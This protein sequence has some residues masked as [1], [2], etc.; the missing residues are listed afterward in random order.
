LETQNHEWQNIQQKGR[1]GRGTNHVDT[2]ATEWISLVHGPHG[3]GGDPLAPP[4]NSTYLTPIGGI[5]FFLQNQRSS[6][7]L[8]PLRLFDPVQN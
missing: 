4:P 8:S 3:T 1:K 5:N 6:V 2:A 7:Q